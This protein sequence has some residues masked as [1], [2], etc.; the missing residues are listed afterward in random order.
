M[1]SYRCSLQ[2]ISTSGQKCRYRTRQDVSSAG[3]SQASVTGGHETNLSSRAGDDSRRPL[4]QHNC[5]DIGC[6]LASR[7]EGVVAPLART[8]EMGKL[9][10]VWREYDRPSRPRHSDRRRCLSY[11]TQGDQTIG[12]HDDRYLGVS[13]KAAHFS[14]GVVGTT[15]TRAHHD[16]LKSRDQVQHLI[17]PT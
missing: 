3:G 13:D 11:V 12:I 16:C 4:E 2:W 7:Q 1:G 6:K 14:A 10:Q 17:G 9:C 5:S 8:R 15:Q